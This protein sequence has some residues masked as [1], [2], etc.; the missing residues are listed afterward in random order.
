MHRWAATACLAAGVWI[1]TGPGWAL[2]T[3]GALVWLL[4]PAGS[5]EL[6]ADAL[7]ERAA[8]AAAAVRGSWARARAMPRRTIAVTTMVVGALLLPLGVGVLAGAAVGVAV[9]AGAG[10]VTAGAEL[11]GLSL[12]T[13]WGA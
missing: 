4:A 10:A 7:R 12:L 3:L 5:G 2:L 11:A 9:G 13:G 1:L 8:G 6:R